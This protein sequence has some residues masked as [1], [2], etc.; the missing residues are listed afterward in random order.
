VAEY[1]VGSFLE[2]SEKNRKLVTVSGQEIV[3]FCHRDT[4]Y[5]LSNYCLHMGGPVGEGKLIGRVE[6]RIAEDGTHLGDRFSD[7][8]THLVCPWHGYEYDIHT[9][10]CAAVPEQKLT[11]YPA[12]VRDGGVYVTL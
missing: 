6:S 4:V 11:R 2:L 3:V 8:V 7:D 9:G 12:E 5:A 10:I 1:L